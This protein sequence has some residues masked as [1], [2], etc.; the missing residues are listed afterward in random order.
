MNDEVSDSHV[1]IILGIRVGSCKS[2]SGFSGDVGDG[3]GYQFQQFEPDAEYAQYFPQKIGDEVDCLLW[4]PMTGR[5]YCWR[6]PDPGGEDYRVVFDM[7][8][9]VFMLA[10][11]AARRTNNRGGL[12]LF[13]LK[14]PVVKD[15]D[16]RMEMTRLQRAIDEIVL[17]NDPD[18]H[19]V[20][21]QLKNG[22]YR[23]WY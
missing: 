23:P 20:V 4:E 22:T 11:T 21:R 2:W 15:K 1:A 16:L 12:A 17:T 10:D 5:I 18:V 8:L 7:S 6:Y 19:D 13:E 14:W 3:E 9:V